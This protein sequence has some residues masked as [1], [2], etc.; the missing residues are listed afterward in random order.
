MKALVNKKEIKKNWKNFIKNEEFVDYFS[1]YRAIQNSI[2]SMIPQMIDFL[3]IEDVYNVFVQLLEVNN[4]IDIML[5]SKSNET[6][7]LCKQRVD[8]LIRE[9]AYDWWI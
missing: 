4:N 7:N 8:Y 6:I 2:K 5:S 3:Y 1:I 9:K